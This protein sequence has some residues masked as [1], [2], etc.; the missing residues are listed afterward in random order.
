[1]QVVHAVAPPVSRR[2]S[3]PPDLAAPKPRAV[4]LR[5]R[6]VLRLAAREV[7]VAVTIQK[8]GRSVPGGVDRLELLAEMSER[9]L[10]R[11][12]GLRRVGESTEVVYSA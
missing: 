1:M 8:R 2:A 5:E 10:L 6:A 7:A 11:Y 9:G 12:A 4:G 3:S